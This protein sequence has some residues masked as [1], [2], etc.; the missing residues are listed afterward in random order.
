MLSFWVWSLG[1]NANGWGAFSNELLE[2]SSRKGTDKNP[3]KRW[4]EPRPVLLQKCVS[5]LLA[6]ACSKPCLREVGA[7]TEE[8]LIPYRSPSRVIRGAGG[9]GGLPSPP[10]VAASS[11]SSKERVAS[12]AV[13]N[14]PSYLWFY[15]AP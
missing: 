14:F 8:I 2:L 1:A 15:K 13:G 4:G 7:S 6:P 10:A 9:E 5:V 11:G 3:S 12:A